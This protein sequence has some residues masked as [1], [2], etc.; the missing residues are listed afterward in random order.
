LVGMPFPRIGVFPS[1]AFERHERLLGAVAEICGVAFVQGHEVDSRL[2]DAGLL[3]GAS[4]VEAVAVARSGLRC[5]AFIGG[6]PSA[7]R[8]ASSNVRLSSTPYL[9]PALRGMGLPD[10][11]VVK[12][13]GLDRESGDEVVAQKGE[14]VLWI[15][16][17]VGTSRMDLLATDPP[18]LSASDYLFARFQDHDWF[19]LLPLLHFAREVSGWTLPPSRACF[20]FDDPNLHW[21]TYGYV[22]YA[23]MAADA[24]AHNYHVSFATVP[25]DG[26]YVHQST[27]R[28]FRENRDRLSLLVHGNNHTHFEL[29]R[30]LRAD[31]QRALAAQAMTRTERLERVSGV[32]VSRVMAAP[33][34]ACSHDMAKAL[35]QAGFDAAC[36]SRGSLMAR[37]PGVTWP[38][39]VGLHP[40]EAF[41]GG[42][43]VIPRSSIRADSETHVRLALFLGQPAIPVGHHD[44]LRGGLDPLRRI[45]R[46]IN[47]AGNVLWTNMTE[48]A[49]MNYMSRRKQDVLHVRM[50]SR[51][52]RVQVPSGVTQLLIERPWLSDGYAERLT[53]REGPAEPATHD[54]VA[55]QHVP[56]LSG[57]DVTI[58]SIH[59]EAINPHDVRA[60][61]TRVHV[62]VRRHLCEGRDRLR[63][64]LDR[65]SWHPSS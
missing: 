32:A 57:S 42:L 5:L 13:C 65:W 63:P 50:Y 41:G 39:S 36:I 51:Q 21:N 22:R 34:G 11:S 17:R 6:S 30:T 23:E 7:V 37:N 2:Y 33:H 53:A 26:W 52:I 55:G 31:R 60:L 14:D 25:M 49:L 62:M 10:P 40:A 35:L 38:V 54:L 3:F 45:A 18:A 64:T 44:D 16:R 46:R 28:L 4:R 56:V 9:P 24:K 61:P 27:A 8:S 58:R 1:E 48:I 20:M 29:H 19:S 47:S 15:H 12:V 59:P 43:P